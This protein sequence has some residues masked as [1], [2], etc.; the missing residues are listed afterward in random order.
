[1]LDF[2]LLIIIEINEGMILRTGKRTLGLL[3]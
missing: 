2:L 3:Q 1:M